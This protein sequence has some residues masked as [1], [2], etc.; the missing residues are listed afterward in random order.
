MSSLLLLFLK[1]VSAPELG[2]GTED[3]VEYVQCPDPV[4]PHTT[5]GT[6]VSELRRED[7]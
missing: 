3:D 7:S 1:G 4:R 5:G 2:I 6:M